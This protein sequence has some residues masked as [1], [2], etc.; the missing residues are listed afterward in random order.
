MLIDTCLFAILQMHNV[1][2]RFRARRGT[3]TAIM[4]LKLAQDLVSI[5][6]DPLFLV[7]LDF[8]KASDTVDRDRLLVTLEGCG[9]GPQVCG[10]L[11][12]FWGYQQVVRRQNGFHGPAFPATRVTTR[13]GLF[14][15]ALLNVVVDNVIRT[16]LTMTLEDQ[17]VPHDGL[18]ETVG[19]FLG[20]F[21]SYDGIVGSRNSDWI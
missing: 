6:Q 5:Y 10:L 12:T 7:F 20:F 21:Y 8:R 19:R 15:P 4:E 3:G 17:R 16:C 13:G 18:V 2:H 14:S 1:L 11:E 9:E